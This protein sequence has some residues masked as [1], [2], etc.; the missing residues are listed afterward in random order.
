MNDVKVNL[1]MIVPGAIIMSEQECSKQLKKPV[2]NRKGK[3]AGKQARDKQGNPLW[4]YTSVPDLAKH[5]RHDMVIKSNGKKEAV[6]IYTRKHKPAKQTININT[7]AYNCFISG[8]IP[9]GY[10]APK[11]FKPYMPIRSHNDRKTKKWVDGVSIEVQAWK[12][13]SVQQR[14]EW[15]LK[16]ICDSLGGVMESYTVF[17]D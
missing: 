11:D 17:N 15:H 14:L 9:Q 6:T 4:Y 13:A 12:A 10:R 5:D 1:T 16:S 8:E 2:I 7:D 3:Y